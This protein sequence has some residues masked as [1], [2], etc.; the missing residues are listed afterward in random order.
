MLWDELCL[1]ELCLAW[2]EDSLTVTQ[3]VIKHHSVTVGFSHYRAL[4]EAALNRLPSRCQVTL[5]A[6]PRL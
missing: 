4:L 6:R 1:L 2:D 5:L 3:Q